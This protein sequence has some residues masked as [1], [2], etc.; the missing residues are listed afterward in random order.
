MHDTVYVK[1]KIL[2]HTLKNITPEE[3]FTGVKPEIEHFRYL[4]AQCIFMYPKRRSPSQTLQGERIRLWDNSESSKTFQIDIPG[5][6]QIETS[7][8]VVLEEEIAF[9][10]SRESQIEIDSE[11][12]P[13]PLSAVQRETVID[14]VDPVDP[15]ALVDV[16][17][18]IVVGHKRHVWARQIL[19]EAEGHETP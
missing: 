1:N 8:D 17:R 13:S 6:R 19:Q 2:H 9:Q 15:I 16:P 3:A 5:Q 14:L 10:R 12:V 7:K 4:G 18:D 11:I